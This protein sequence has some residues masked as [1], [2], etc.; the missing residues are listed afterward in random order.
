MLLKFTL[1]LII[2]VILGHYYNEKDNRKL[3][4]YDLI[5]EYLLNEWSDK[6]PILWIH[7]HYQMNARKWKNFSSRNSKKL[8]QPYIQLCIQSIIK[9][10]GN[11]F[12]IVL[13]SDTSFQ[14]LIPNWNI[15]SRKFLFQYKIYPMSLLHLK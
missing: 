2:F 4:K 6:K 9:H 8:N 7:N 12:N 3:D 13:I 10:C 11:S 15:R 5:Q 14:K 1:L